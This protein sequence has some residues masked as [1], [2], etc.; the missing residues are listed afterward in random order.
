MR[1]LPTGTVTFLVTDIEGSTR[2]IE[3]LGEEG[4]SHALAEHRRVVRE[5]CER[6]EGVEVDTQ[7]DAFFVAFRTAP[8]GLQAAREAQEALSIPVRMG[9]HTGTPLV[10]DEGYVGAD[11][12]KAARIA[13]AG[14]GGQVLISSATAALAGSVGLRDLGEHRLRDLSAPERIFQLGEGEFPRLKTLHQTNLPVPMT[15]FLG[16][17]RELAEIAALVRRAELRV[18]TLCGPGGT[19]KTRLALQA[20]GEATDRYPDGVFWVPLAALRDA[21]LVLEQVAQAVGSRNGLAEHVGDKRLLLLLDNFEQVVEAAPK[22]GELLQVCPNLKLIITSRELL[23]IVGEVEYAVP[24]LAE[25]EAVELFCTRAQ[26]EPD[27]TIAE[28]CRR[29]DNLPLALEL[30]AART[31]VLSPAQILERLAHR[32]DLLKG[33]RNAEPRQQTLRATIEWSHDLLDDDEQRLFARLAVF[34]GGCTLEAA[35]QVAEANLDTLESL[36]DKSLVRHTGERLWM[37]ETIHQYARERLSESGDEPELRRRHA[38]FFLRLVEET[39]RQ[40]EEGNV[41][42]SLALALIA[43]E[44]DNVR[45][46]LEWARDLR[47]DE[48]LLGLTAPLSDYWVTRG[49]YGELQAWAPLALERASSPRRARARLFT[50]VA[51]GALK[52]GDFG[53]AEDLITEWGLEAERT[54]DRSDLLAPM[55]TSAILAAEQGDFDRA[56]A[57]WLRVMAV[58]GEIGDREREASTAVNLAAIACKSGDPRAGFE[59]ATEA[60]QLFCNLGAEGGTASALLNR[61]WSALDLGNGSAAEVSFRESLVIARRLGAVPRIA[62]GASGLGVTLVLG[63]QEKCGAQLLGAAG[64]LYKTLESGPADAVEEELQERAVA[65]AKTALGEE[66][67]A[68]AWAGGEAMTPDDIV[69]LANEASG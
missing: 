30:A 53:R 65:A 35:E 51:F 28:L 6:H 39:D 27:E 16:R 1:Q 22:L 11:V 55:N 37:L 24:P 9:I 34:R 47:E 43:A 32:L 60:A 26:V 20:A 13:A 61:G 38:L 57:E 2:L 31:S 68:E 12:H 67:F 69:Q 42:Q 41:P 4:Y 62:S 48:V 33:G 18:L 25:S 5:A 36:V 58:A 49:F 21:P 3:Q 40:A 64:A 52:R 23:R 66:A 56:R 7:G 29:L 44:H 45:A 15:P 14:H 8:G 10:T 54:G 63:G 50:H 19:G 46:V 17:E 59:Y